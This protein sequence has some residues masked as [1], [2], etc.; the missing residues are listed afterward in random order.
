[1]RDGPATRHLFAVV[2]C[3]TL[4]CSQSGCYG[5]T[6]TFNLGGLRNPVV[7]VKEGHK[8]YDITVRFVAVDA[9]DTATNQKLNREKGRGFALIALARFMGLD[10]EESIAVAGFAPTG[11]LS[12]ERV[13][14]IG[15][16]VGK[17]E[18]QKTVQTGGRNA[19]S[20]QLAGKRQVPSGAVA[21]E[22]E[23]DYRDTIH[24]IDACGRGSAAD[25]IEGKGD[26]YEEI[27]DVEDA[28]LELFGTVRRQIGEDGQL[29][30]GER[31]RLFEDI[32]RAQR[33]FLSVLKAELQ[34]LEASTE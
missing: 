15:F 6:E 26:L 8:V 12:D 17:D 29:A 32:D 21:A 13:I 19:A 10:N 7:T 31:S 20:T 23:T 11:M 2:I 1:M 3:G 22:V 27:A 28:T 16:N 30:Q 9:F 18:V 34:V 5:R 33:N 4:L 24:L 25:L 14:E